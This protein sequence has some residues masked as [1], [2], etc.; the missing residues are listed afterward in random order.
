MSTV[1]VTQ[2][3]LKDLIAAALVR[4]DTSAGNA[5]L[6]AAALVA[7][8]TDGQKGHGASRVESYSAQSA[9][10][11]VDGHA[12]PT[13]TK[14]AAAAL[15]VD[16]GNGFSFPAIDLAVREL[17]AL[18]PAT[19]IAVAAIHRSHHAGQMGAHVERLAEAGLVALMVANTPKAMAPWGGSDGVFG[20]NPIA[21]AAPR[22]DLPPLVID[23][24]LSKVARGKI[25]V[26]S[27]K[28][29]PIPDDW[30]RG[31]DGRPTTDA[32]AALAGTLLPIGDA[33]GAALALMVE[34]LAAAVTGAALAG[35]AAS[36]FTGEGD[37]PAVGQLII[38]ID[39]GSLS[40]GLF[41]E[42]LETLLG[43]MAAQDGVRLPG[44]RR[45]AAREAAARDGLTLPRAQYDQILGLAGRA[46]N[47]PET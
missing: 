22:G 44:T 2:A 21:F 45:L 4:H 10:G 7:A 28:G 12:V 31:P 25:L 1:T 9:S 3:E 35:E 6:V 46:G 8:E 18:A 34:V 36:F 17:A 43:S 27:Q 40:G 38:A 42:R 26:A 24:S 19:G 15:R 39:P 14:V 37:P 11:K 20:T 32:K 5:D 13:C 16:A 23:L 47:Q 29:E 41:A 33:K 30:A